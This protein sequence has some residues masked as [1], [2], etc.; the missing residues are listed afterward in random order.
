MKLALN[1]DIGKQMDMDQIMLPYRL[2]DV[3]EARARSLNDAYFN[4]IYGPV[5]I[6]FHGFA[7]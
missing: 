4:N 3:W 5:I 6:F 7:R 2:Y 1:E